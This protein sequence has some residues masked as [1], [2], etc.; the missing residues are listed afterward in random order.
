MKK[1]PLPSGV[2]FP[3]A[4]FIFFIFN[5][6]ANVCWTVELLYKKITEGIISDIGIYKNEK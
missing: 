5:S 3:R 4:G 6:K 1:P 2:G